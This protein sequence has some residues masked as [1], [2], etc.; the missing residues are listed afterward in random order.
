MTDVMLYDPSSSPTSSA[1][2][3][4]DPAYALAK[5]MACTSFVPAAYQNKP[6]ELLAAIL[7]G[8]ELGIGP[9]AAMAKI[10][11]IQGRAGISAELMRALPLSHGHVIW[12]EEASPSKVVVCGHRKGD[13]EHVSRIT[14]TAD[15]V[16]RA[17]L[18]GKENHRKYPQAMMLARATGDLC[19]TIFADCL[20]GI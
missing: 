5:K 9:M 4:V 10:H 16:K 17:G 3:L 15:M 11:N 7:T 2:A 8:H 18:E 19:R 12:V 1:L 6:D 14:W 20:A 13:P